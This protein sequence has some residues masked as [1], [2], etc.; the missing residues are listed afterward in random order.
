MRSRSLLLLAA[1]VAFP[2]PAFTQEPTPA[3]AIAPVE[4]TATGPELVAPAAADPAPSLA[5]PAGTVAPVAEAVVCCPIEV[6]AEKVTLAG[7]L[8]YRRFGAGTP[9]VLCVDNPADCP[10]DCRG[11]LFSVA[12]CVPACCVGEPVCCGTHVGLLGR[13]YVKY[14]W[15]CGFEATIVFRV[16]GGVM[17]VYG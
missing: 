9:Q 6:V 7:R 1:A 5:K 12:V 8:A 2:L 4:A 15:P 17:I 13:G 16:H 10:I 14:R 11:D 3:E